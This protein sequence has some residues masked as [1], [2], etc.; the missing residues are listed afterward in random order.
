ME[1]VSFFILRRLVSHE[2]YTWSCHCPRLEARFPYHGSGA[3][4]RS[5]SPLAWRPDFPGAPREAHWPHPSPD[6]A[7]RSPFSEGCPGYHRSILHAIEILFPTWL[8]ACRHLW[9][10]LSCPPM[11]TCRGT[12]WWLTS[13]CSNVIGTTCDWD[14][15]AGPYGTFPEQTFPQA[16]WVPFV[17]RKTLVKE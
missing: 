9:L 2:N 17:C 8:Q 10:I 16:L 3:V 12:C 5:P 1:K 15:W 13:R 7:S 14:H 6:P 11:S 4:T